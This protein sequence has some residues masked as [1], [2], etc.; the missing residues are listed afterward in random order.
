MN[1]EQA[2]KN[3]SVKAEILNKNL[4]EASEKLLTETSL[5]GKIKLL[6]DCEQNIRAYK[7]NTV[8]S[9]KP[10]SRALAHKGCRIADSTILEM[11]F[12]AVSNPSAMESL[13]YLLTGRTT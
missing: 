13:N 9:Y 3:L 10:I 7:Q 5:D 6:H 1:A 2:L 4:Q 12:A 11:C 8:N